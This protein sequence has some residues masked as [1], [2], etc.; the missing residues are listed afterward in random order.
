[1]L[2]KILLTSITQ[3]KRKGFTANHAYTLIE[4]ANLSPAIGSKLRKL[5][6][7]IQTNKFEK[8]VIEK[9][10]WDVTIDGKFNLSPK[11]SIVG[12]L[13]AATLNLPLD[14]A[15]QEVQGVAE[16]LDDRNTKWQRIA[17]AMGWRTWNVGAENEEHDL[18]KADAGVYKTKRR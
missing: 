3:K 14:R 12:D 15:I 17:M 10:G 8:D 7:A 16:A 18:I 4:A 6:T 11:Y 9:R 2:L 13:A 1:L 5:H